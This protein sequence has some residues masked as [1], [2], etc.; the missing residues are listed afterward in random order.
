MAKIEF[1]SDTIEVLK[2]AETRIK[3]EIETIQEAAKVP[4]N[5]LKV[6]GM[7]IKAET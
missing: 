5:V 4:S 1:K 6:P 2:E 3:N 7:L